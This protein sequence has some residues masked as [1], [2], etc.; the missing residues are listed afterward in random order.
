MNSNYKLVYSEVLNTWVAVAEHVSARGKKSALRLVTAAAFMAGGAVG[1]G[2][3]L[4]APPLIT[5]PAVNQ[6][7]TGAQ[8]AAGTVSFSQT[9]TATAASM[10]VQQSSN[11]AIVNWQSFN[12]GANAKVN[13]TQPNASSVLLNRVQSSDPS[14]I[15]GQINANG[16]V[17]LL[18]PNGVYFAPGSRVDVGSFTASTHSISDA[19]FLNGKHQF[20]RNGATGSILN[21]GHITSGLGGYIALLAPEV[22]NLG[23]VVAQVGGT[24]ALAAGESFELQFNSNKQLTNVLVTPA[25]IQTLV[26]NGQAVQAPGGLII[27]SAQ[28]ASGLLGGVVKNSGSISATG[29]VNDGGTIR[30]SASHNIELAQTSSISADAAPSSSANGGRIDIITDLGNASGITQVDGTISAKGGE[31]GGDG[32]FVDTSA[33]RLAIGENTLVTTGAAKGNAGTWLLDPYDITI[34]GPSGTASGTAYSDNFT[35]GATST[36]LASTI[37]DALNAGGNVTISTG[38]T[39]ANTVGS[40]TVNG[41]ITWSTAKTLTLSANYNIN[42]NAA[43]TASAASGAGVVLEYNQGNAGGTYDFGLSASG[44]AGK[45]TFGGTANSYSTKNYNTTTAY[46]LISNPLSKGATGFNSTATTL[47]GNFALIDDYDNNSASIGSTLYSTWSATFDGLGHI[48]KNITFGTSSSP[49][50]DYNS[51]FATVFNGTF[52][53]LGIT[54]AQV[55]VNLSGNTQFGI[56]AG[57]ANA[58]ALFKNLYIG[59]TTGVTVN[60]GRFVG[61][62]VGCFCASGTAQNIYVDGLTLEKNIPNT[63]YGSDNTGGVFGITQGTAQA[64]DMR[65]RDIYLSN[66]TIKLTGSKSSGAY[67]ASLGGITGLFNTSSALRDDPLANCYKCTVSN[68]TV[69]STATYGVYVG[70][71]VGIAAAGINGA[72]VTNSTVS[73]KANT[74]TFGSFPPSVGGISGASGKTASTVAYSTNNLFSGGTVISQNTNNGN[75]Y[76]T[77][78]GSLYGGWTINLINCTDACVTSQLGNWSGNTYGNTANSVSQTI[79]GVTYT[80]TSY[81]STINGVYNGAQPSQNIYLYVI[82]NQTGTY[83][84]ATPL[85]Y[86]YSTSATN[87]GNGYIASI[88]PSSLQGI[89]VFTAGATSV[90]PSATGVSGAITINQPLLSTLSAGSY[91]LS[92]TPSSLTY[93]GANFLTGNSPTVQINKAVLNIATSKTYDRTTAFTNANTYALSGTL[94][95]GDASPTI[96][97]GSADSSGANAATYTS[98]SSN[99]LV[100]SNSNYTLSGGTVS[101]TINKANATVTANSGLLTYNGANQTVTGFTATG[102]V[103]SET[104]AVLTG[105]SASRTA[106]NAGTYAVTPSGTDSNY[107]LS[108]VDGSMQ[109][110]KVNATVTANSGLLTY[111]GANQTVSGFTASGLVGSETASVLTGVSASRTAKNAG[112]YAVTPSGTDSNYNLSFVDGSMQIAKAPLVATGNS[113]TVTYNGASQSV[114]GFTLSGLLGSDTATDL[115][116]VSATGAAGQNAGSYTNTVSAGTEAN[117]TVSTVN[118][119]LSIAKANA[120]VTANSSSQSPTT[121]PT[122][123]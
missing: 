37:S 96:A 114:S 110:D 69:A 63:G 112:T 64:G 53:N 113:A 99:S 89:Q 73:L 97:S 116:T 119:N 46:T 9:Q 122:K 55:Y 52:Q 93:S 27:L 71:I 2:A 31:Q 41:P 62:V 45:I 79:G 26:D 19:D 98:F 38:T 111:N 43:I 117:Y 90:T 121:A 56:F 16:Q 70:G 94:Y 1:T 72:T 54:S 100:L 28:A 18:N 92:L 120:T 102:L 20:N 87:Y 48:I 13:I 101:A 7:P 10:A 81:T 3:S 106:K 86:W 108:F 36:I 47:T 91:T 24:V 123:A 12:V 68:S 74:T 51:I 115:L 95:N 104:A 109:I 44:F 66:S 88:L 14:Q 5:P 50:N 60:G 15:F 67:P 17:L 84:S 29:L 118:G 33:A 76:N 49:L 80:G 85:N 105:V 34:A 61:S 40:I 75:S 6:L 103:G 22:R 35:A 83:G 4:A 59:G 11:Q 30:L 77:Y 82:E 21:E 32:G 23:V 107:N 65:V 42:I 39:A 25:T 58:G 8:V 78:T 57:Q